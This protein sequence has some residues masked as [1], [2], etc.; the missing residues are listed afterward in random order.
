[1]SPYV[2]EVL[3]PQPFR[4][5]CDE[6]LRAGV[7]SKVEIGHLA[8]KVT[9]ARLEFDLGLGER[10]LH[11][12]RYELQAIERIDMEEALHHADVGMWEVYPDL[13]DIEAPQKELGTHGPRRLRRDSK[14]TEE[15]IRV[16]H[17]MHQ[18]RGV[19]IRELGRT[20]WDQAGFASPGAA[21]RS[22]GRGFHR[23]Q[24]PVASCQVARAFTL[25]EGSRTCRYIKPSGGQCG[26]FAMR[27]SDVCWAH[28][29]DNRVAVLATALANS[30]FA[31]A[32]A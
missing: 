2:A 21:A 32:V 24:L 11:R 25:S 26:T 1:M 14:L 6:R 13:P 5:W 17:R 3:D 7:E 9:V 8:A 30:P 23:F 20:I 27:D 12:W 16:L 31:E 28:D 18:E 22:I 10:R 4:D 19:S 15:Q 29:P